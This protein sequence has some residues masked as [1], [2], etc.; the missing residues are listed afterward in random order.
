MEGNAKFVFRTK[1]WS[2]LSHFKVDQ[3]IIAGIVKLTVEREQGA[4]GE[5]LFDK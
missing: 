5:H 4:I 1:K 2:P 3:K